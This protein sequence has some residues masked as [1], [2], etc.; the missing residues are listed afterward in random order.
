MRKSFFKFYQFQ[1]KPNFLFSNYLFWTYNRFRKSLIFTINVRQIADFKTFIL[2][3]WAIRRRYRWARWDKNRP[4]EFFISVL[5]LLYI[6]TLVSRYSL[7]FIAIH[8]RRN[9]IVCTNSH[10]LDIISDLKN[11][12]HQRFRTISNAIIR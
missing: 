2:S 5:Y 11:L 9:S 3:L 7:S 10:P 8:R 4:P 1:L 12:Q 6:G